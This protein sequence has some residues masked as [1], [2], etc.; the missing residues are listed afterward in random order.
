MNMTEFFEIAQEFFD[1][2]NP[3]FSDEYIEENEES[4]L[5]KLCEDFFEQMRP[6]I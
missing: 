5:W 2:M 4:E 3:N 1:L 6:Q